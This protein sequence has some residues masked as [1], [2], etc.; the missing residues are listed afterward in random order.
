MKRNNKEDTMNLLKEWAISLLVLACIVSIFLGYFWRVHHEMKQEDRK[1]RMHVEQFL[2][3]IF[4]PDTGMV[5]HY[6]EYTFIKRAD[7][8]IIIRRR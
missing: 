5:S 4:S 3:E 1:Y 7:G 2:H 6:G 8:S